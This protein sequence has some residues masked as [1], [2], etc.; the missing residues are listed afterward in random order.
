MVFSTFQILSFLSTTVVKC[1]KKVY[2]SQK[3]FLGNYK[4]IISLILVDNVP[5]RLD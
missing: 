4:T 1:Q 3:N 2:N 5:I